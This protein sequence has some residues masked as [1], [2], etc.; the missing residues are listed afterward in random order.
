[1]EAFVYRWTDSSNGKMYVGSHKGTIDDGYVGSGK[2]FRLAYKKRPE[3]FSREILYI[4]TYEDVLELEEFILTE[5]DASN[6][7]E[8]YNLKNTAVGGCSSRSKQSRLKQSKTLTG[9]KL[10]K[11]RRDAMSKARIG[12]VFSETH[13]K[14]IS[15]AQTG[16]NNNNARQVY[17][18]YLN[19][20]FE[21]ISSCAKALGVSATCVSNQIRG[22]RKNRFNVSYGDTSI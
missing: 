1:M 4:G 20:T 11:K 14:N 10:S 6:S 22:K 16:A 18:G 15:Q 7:D 19:E 8:Y 17:C 9:K 5:L 3:A 21:T 2:I 13:R 12:I